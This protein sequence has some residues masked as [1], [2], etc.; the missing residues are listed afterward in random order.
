LKNLKI[1][2]RIGLAY[3][4]ILFLFIATFTINFSSIEKVSASLGD[5]YSHPFKANNLIWNIKTDLMEIQVNMFKSASENDKDMAQ[6]YIS[7]AQSKLEDLEKLKAELEEIY[8]GDEKYMTQLSSYIVQ[9]NEYKEQIFEYLSKEEDAKA[10]EII[11]NDY[12]PLIERVIANIGVI[13]AYE[14]TVSLNYLNEANNIKK[15]SKKSLASNCVFIVVVIII[16]WVV[17][18]LSIIK[19]IKEIEKAAGEMCKGNLKI[20]IKYKAKDEIGSL[21]ESM[22]STVNIMNGYISNIS[23]N[24]KKLSQKDLSEAIEMEYVGDFIN[25]KEA[26]IDI[27]DNY[28][29]MIKKIR[30][31]AER[32]STGAQ[33][34]ATAAQALET[35]ASDQSS[36]VEQL[37]ATVHNVTDQVEVNANN[38]NDVNDLSSNSVNE[39]EKGNSSMQDLL[40]AMKQ[41]EEQSKQ[42]ANII[43]VINNIAHQTNLLALNAGIEAARAGDNGLGFAVVA[44]SIGNLAGECSQAAKNTEELINKTMAAVYNGTQLAGE[45][46]DVLNHM[47]Q[48][49]S[50]TSTLVGNIS[51]A[52]TNQ[53]KEL[54]EILQGIQQIAVVVETNSSTAA[55]TSASSEELLTQAESLD[56]MMKK[57]KVR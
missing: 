9:S 44:T 29:R 41:I 40:E 39:I 5:F 42:T 51:E 52:C 38:A 56:E 11:N 7:L 10:L 26:M 25:I 35:G 57:F 22:R 1:G 14:E 13:A 3:I 34:I 20:D 53:S 4:L 46:A 43:K 17:I 24:L 6:Q 37:V 23:D 36:A 54:K 15:H 18:T 47:V 2:L 28:N 32:V 12:L 16:L 21:A 8:T 50:K 49:V 48:S 27:T 19:P 45:T 55:E 31:A 30:G 33:Q